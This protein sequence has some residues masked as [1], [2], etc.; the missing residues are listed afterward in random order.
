MLLLPALLGAALLGRLGA[1]VGLAAAVTVGGSRFG[2]DGGGLLVLLCRAPPLWLAK[3][4]PRSTRAAARARRRGRRRSVT[5]VGL[6]AALGG[7]S[8]VTD[9]VTDGPGAILCDLADR[10]ES[11]PGAASTARVSSASR[12]SRRSHG[13]RR[14]GRCHPSRAAAG[15]A[16]CLAARQRHAGRRPLDRRRRRRHALAVRDGHVCT[17]PVRLRAMRRT[18][19]AVGFSRLRSRS[20]GRLQQQPEAEPTPETVVGA[21]PDETTEAGTRI[22]RRSSSTGDAAAG[23]EV[24][25]TTGCGGC[26]TLAAAGS[27]GAVGPNLDDSKPA[28]RSSPSTRVTK[29]QGGMP[30]FEDSADAAADRGRRRVR[31]R[32]D[33]RLTPPAGLPAIVSRRS[34]ATSTAR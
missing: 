11:R 8:H 29:G 23:K 28:R 21:L 20:R 16:R 15:R 24:F 2:A 17:E 12:R 6:D 25:A 7:S 9:A 34:P 4:V 14:A 18:T 30:P 19:V 13:S 32:V 26:H 1:V 27:S 5:A 31:R 3:G 33:R 22:C 10:W